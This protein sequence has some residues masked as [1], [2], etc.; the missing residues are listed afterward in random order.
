MGSATTDQQILP[1]ALELVA[2]PVV[3]V[4]VSPFPLQ[5]FQ[6]L[7]QNVERS[8]RV[9]IRKLDGDGKHASVLLSWQSRNRRAGSLRRS[10]A[11]K[12]STHARQTQIWLFE[13]CVLAD[14][15][16]LVPVDDVLWTPGV[17]TSQRLARTGPC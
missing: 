14:D 7:L 13:L 5:E 12:A 16:I 6:S 8:D 11:S 9:R 15:G 17:D 4:L 10:L 3:V 2:H 1:H